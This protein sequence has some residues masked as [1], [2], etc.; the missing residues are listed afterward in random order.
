MTRRILLAAAA[1][2]TASAAAA[3]PALLSASPI[4]ES[5]L[6][7]RQA[8]ILGLLRAEP[9]VTD[10]QL[11]TADV[12]LLEAD[13]DVRV[14]LPGAPPV[15]VAADGAERRA[16]GDLSWAGRAAAARVAD[17][18]EAVFVSR[19]GSLTGTVRRG[20]AVYTVRPLTGGLHAVARVAAGRAEHAGDF[21]AFVAETRD[22]VERARAADLPAEATRRNGL[23]EADVLVVYTARVAAAYADPVAFAQLAVAQ[24]NA[25]YAVSGIGVRLTLATAY[26]S[27]TAE[28]ALMATDLPALQNTADGRFD[29]L[30][31]V[32]N[33]YGADLVV[34]LGAGYTDACGLG[35]VNPGA[36]FAFSVVEV[37]C[38]VSTYTF[39]HEVGH[40]FGAT[41][42]PY[43]VTAPA[44][45]YGQGTVDL[46]GRWRT[47]MAYNNQCA[48]AG[49][50]CTSVGYW[51]APD[52]IYP[53]ATAPVNAGPTGNAATRDN[54]RLL[55]ERAPILSAFRA[56]PAAAVLGAPAPL[57]VVLAPGQTAT[58]A[59]EIRNTA[60]PGSRPLDWAVAVVG[61]DPGECAAPVVV[62]QGQVSFYVN[63]TAGGGEYGQS[64]TPPCSGL[65]RAV[66]PQVYGPGSAG[67][68]WTATLRLYAG[69]G[70]GGAPLGTA[71]VTSVNGPGS[72]FVPIPLPVPV[73]VTQGQPVTWFL[74]LES[75]T[76]P[77]LYSTENPLAGGTLVRS[78]NGLPSGA[79]AQAGNDMTFQMTF[80]PPSHWATPATQR[81]STAPGAT[82]SVP[83]AISTDGLAPGTYPLT[84][85][86]T[87]S[88]PSAPT[89][90]VPLALTVAMTAAEVAPARGLVL[91]APAPNP[92]RGPAVLGYT[93]AEA[94]PVRLAVTD[95]LGREVA[96]VVD[97]EAAAGRHTATLETARLAPGVY[98]V[99]LSAEAEAAV[100]RLVVVR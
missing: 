81:G 42:D 11:V 77:V 84:L 90:S 29:E 71:P 95:L 5:A 70:T 46:A 99:R 62:Q 35:Y 61:S 79:A 3:Q 22:A 37:G 91:D 12:S 44:Y 43:V 96:V 15:V 63:S 53:D 47:V 55:G 21:E 92:T 38:A 80:G 16:P 24:S 50:A 66:A 23:V 87:T 76:A 9:G 13:Q 72:V 82:S 93:L 78:P 2:L 39:P 59:V 19:A 8:E 14:D 30:H 40:N 26:E 4:A 49:F 51:S 17:T 32:R 34:L 68:S 57:S 69:A 33:A 18:A 54:A 74:D 94:G 88:D 65:V 64:V 48:D 85:V 97:G 67:T 20:D 83:V 41:H 6:T 75:G 45:P 86:V 7:P 60:A 100:R 98:V 89:A 27:P 56:R 31:A 36:T 28:T 73:A 25:T 52:L 58:R 1:L 10:V